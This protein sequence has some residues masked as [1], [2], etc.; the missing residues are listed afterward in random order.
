M[1][2]V[3]APMLLIVGERDEEVI[4]LDKRALDRLNPEKELVVVPGATHLFEKPRTLEEVA[5]QA[6]DWFL[7]FGK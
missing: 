2:G 3:E 4:E 7:R 6:N 1:G 5:R